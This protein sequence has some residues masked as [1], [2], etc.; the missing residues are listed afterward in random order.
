MTNERIFWDDF[1]GAPD[2][3]AIVVKTIAPVIHANGIC[4][5]LKK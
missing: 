1:R 5:K 3:L 2:R 4:I